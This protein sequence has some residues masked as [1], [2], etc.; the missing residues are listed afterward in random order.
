M[1]S[2]LDDAG[3]F[4]LDP[5]TMR[6]YIAH[7]SSDSPVGP[8]DFVLIPRLA[9]IMQ[10]EGASEIDLVGLTFE[11]QRVTVMDPH[12]VPSGGDWGLVRPQTN[13]SQSSSVQWHSFRASLPIA[14][15]YPLC[16]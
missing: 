13:L 12:G 10:F 5:S 6:L 14:L 9:T 8:L 1:A 7:N 16:T 11:D 4:W 3:E 2:E 15:V